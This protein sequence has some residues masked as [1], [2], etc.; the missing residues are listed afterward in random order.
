MFFTGT[1]AEL[2]PVRSLDRITIGSGKAGPI[3]RQMQREYLGICKGE[4]EDRHGWLTHCR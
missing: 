1:A 4:I 3:T 2:T